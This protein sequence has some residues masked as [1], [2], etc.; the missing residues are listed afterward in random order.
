MSP[1]AT[2]FPP[3]ASLFRLFSATE[4]KGTPVASLAIGAALLVAYLLLAKLGLT[5][6]F[7]HGT[8]SPVWPPTGLAI[9]ALTLWGPRL[10]PAVTL[11]AWA[12]N[13]FIAK[14]PV[15]VAAGI[16]VG[17]TLEAVA[18]AVVLR[19]RGTMGEVTCVRD[20]LVIL[21]VSILAPL[22]SAGGGVLSLTLG[23]LLPPERFPWVWLVW[24]MGDVMG[25]LMVLPLILAWAGRRA[26][27]AAPSR[28]IEFAGIVVLVTLSLWACVFIFNQTL[29]SLGMDRLPTGAFLFPPI[30]WAML[31]LPP[32]EVLAVVSIIGGMAV[33]FTL[34][35]TPGDMIGPLV[36]L[37]MVLFCLGGGSLL[38]V[39]ALAER[40]QAAQ[41]LAEADRAKG[42]FVAVIRHDLGQ[43]LQALH[44]FIG[45][46]E[47]R[48]AGDLEQSLLARMTGAVNAMGTT[49]DSLRDVTLV[50]CVTD[51][52]Q[53]DPAEL[54][55]FLARVGGRHSR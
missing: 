22:P 1:H 34:A 17:N 38:V 33:A 40:C 26:P 11:G 54:D 5:M 48:L 23:G 37:Q 24:W 32:R 52:P 15:T 42:R 36:W 35:V 46:L 41:A 29:A 10:W 8:V 51:D 27:A 3:A 4:T 7:V 43:P 9:A 16:A 20:A 44:L 25:A 12:V 50:E 2:S 53:S 49:L 21:A 55:E 6:S 19:R 47:G 14:D 13:V 18:G 28:P 45:V 31:R 39:G 30:A